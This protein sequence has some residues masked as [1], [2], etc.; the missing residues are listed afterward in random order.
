MGWTNVK[1][2]ESFFLKT[3]LEN[4]NSKTQKIHFWE[5]CTIIKGAELR[6]G[7]SKFK[8]PKTK[9]IQNRRG[10]KLKGS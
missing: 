10:S 6:K 8:G 3:P 5:G 2:G 1:G 7:V 9:G 4:H